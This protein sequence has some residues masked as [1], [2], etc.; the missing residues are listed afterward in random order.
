MDCRTHV[1]MSNTMPIEVVESHSILPDLVR[2]GGVVVDC[3]AN[4][5]AFSMEMIRR[6]ECQCYA[7][8]ASPAVFARMAKH[9]NIVSRNIAICDR[10][11]AVFITTEEDITR[12]RVVVGGRI[13][14]EPLV[15]VEGRQLAAV[16]REFGVD[17]IEVLKM[18]IE[19]AELEVI[20]SLDDEFLSKIG[21]LT[22]EFH[23]FLGYAT[24]QDVVSR[25]D[26]IVSLGFWELYWSQRRNTGDVLL[27]N[28]RRMSWPRYMCE[29]EIVRLVRGAG[30][31]WQRTQ[32]KNRKAIAL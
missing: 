2:C 19:G 24:T 23:D 28:R 18:D 15:Q 20:D 6:F 10:D 29:Q 11:R 22:I 27:V 30:R 31:R 3:G 26:R 14:A 25:I 7:F 9:S 21:Q 13:G 8:E 12:N 1:L 16:L 5:G 4:L 32:S 17:Q